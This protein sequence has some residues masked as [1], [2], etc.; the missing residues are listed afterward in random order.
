MKRVAIYVDVSNLY[1]CIYNKHKGKLDYAKLLEFLGP[2]GDIRLSKAYGAQ[3]RDEAAPFIEILKTLGFEP[4]YKEPKF[5]GQHEGKADWDVG[6]AID[7]IKDMDHYDMA[8]LCSADG[9]MIPVVEYLRERGKDVV[10]LG[11]GI[12][13]ELQEYATTCIEIPMSMVIK[14]G[15]R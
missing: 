3:V 2:I 14:K 9:D 10:I 1:Y 8:V 12:S 15:K 11:A 5:Y 6:I 4:H 7:M 13:C